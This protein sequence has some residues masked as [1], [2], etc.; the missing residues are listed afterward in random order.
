MEVTPIIR[1]CEECSFLSEKEMVDE[2]GNE[3]SYQCPCC[4][5]DM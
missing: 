2:Y 3:G 4:G 1:I 5:L